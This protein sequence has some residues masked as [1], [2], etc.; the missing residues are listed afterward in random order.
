MAAI[1]IEAAGNAH[2]QG[3]VE[4]SR[5]RG[6]RQPPPLSGRPMC[7]GQQVNAA[8]R[9]RTEQEHRLTIETEPLAR[10]ELLEV[11]RPEDGQRHRDVREHSEDARPKP[12]G[13]VRAGC[14]AASA[15]LMPER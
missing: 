12:R 2:A 8:R 5:H 13:R 11:T 9:Q 7:P 15:P 10:E 3:V 14:S 6:Q 1:D 4:Q